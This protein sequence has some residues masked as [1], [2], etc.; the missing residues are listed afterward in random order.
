MC[1]I[2]AY[3]QMPLRNVHIHTKTRH[4]LNNSK[5]IA[6]LSGTVRIEFKY[7]THEIHFSSFMDHC[8]YSK[9]RNII[10]T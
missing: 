10:F 7:K 8:S 2:A 3:S 9:Y 4:Y 6:F 1:I 5:R